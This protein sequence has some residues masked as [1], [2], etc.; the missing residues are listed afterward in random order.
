MGLGAK[1]RGRRDNGME[2]IIVFNYVQ[3]HAEFTDF[4]A[5]V[6]GYRMRVTLVDGGEPYFSCVEDTEGDC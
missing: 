4:E 6:N 1:L 2:Q 5:Y 3:K